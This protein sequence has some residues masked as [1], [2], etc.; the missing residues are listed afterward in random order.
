MENATVAAH[1]WIP[2]R[3]YFPP[4]HKI[5]FFVIRCLTI[6]GK[7]QILS[8]GIEMLLLTLFYEEPIY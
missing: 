5:N 4:Q 6:F 7:N 1:P 8:E 3:A 2:L